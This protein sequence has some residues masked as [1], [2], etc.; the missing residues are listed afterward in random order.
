MARLG[1][2][3]EGEGG[4]AGFYWLSGSFRRIA[5]KSKRSIPPDTGRP[6][7]VDLPVF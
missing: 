7:L 3:P 1:R 2:R 4:L 5:A 6:R